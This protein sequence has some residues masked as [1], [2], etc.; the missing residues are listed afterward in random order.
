MLHSAYHRMSRL[1][2]NSYV[3]YTRFRSFTPTFLCAPGCP[4]SYSVRPM[5]PW[6]NLLKTVQCDASE[7]PSR[8][9]AAMHTV[10]AAVAV[11][12][13]EIKRWRRTFD[14]NAKVVNGEK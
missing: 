10:R 13:T 6:S 3:I 12:E 9:A 4:L 1:E 5:F 7:Q 2:P 14:A 8:A 11:P